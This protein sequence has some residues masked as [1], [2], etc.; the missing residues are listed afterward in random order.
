[1]NI[2]D[3][4]QTETID[5]TASEAY[6]IGAVLCDES[7]L[8]EFSSIL[9]PEMFQ[10]SLFGRTWQALNSMAASNQPISIPTLMATHKELAGRIGIK[11]LMSYTTAYIGRSDAHW[12]VQKI[13]EMHYRRMI[14]KGSIELQKRATDLTGTS[15]DELKGAF[16]QIAYSFEQGA[17][18]GL[19]AGADQAVRWLESVE[20]RQKDPTIA[21]G[22]QTGWTDLDLITLGWQ[23]GD[24]IIIGGRTSVGKTAFATENMIRLRDNGCKVAMFSLEMSSEQVKNRLA[25]NIAD[26]RLASIRTGRMEMEELIR[27]GNTIDTISD[28]AIDDNRG[29]TTDYIV[30]E[31]KRWKRMNGL[32]FVVVDYLQEI[33]EPPQPQDNTGSALGRV[34]RKLRK[35]AKDCDCALMALS[36]LTRDAEG[37]A[38]KISDLFGSSGLES[39][40][41]LIVMLHRDKEESPKM[42]ELNVAKQRNGPTSKVNLTYD[43]AKQRIVG[44][45]DKRYE[46]ARQ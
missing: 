31:M 20:K 22:M 21:F 11:R 10:Q 2:A 39:A 27:V 8:D 25:G 36:Q 34:A 35:A 19:S 44:I 5:S 41:D 23:R 28:I 32:D 33:W 29:V 14:V 16:E 37:K 26:V 42:L 45:H 13:V 17:A 43:L 24:L 6:V 40:A 1:M 38:P 46:G 7:L 12:H 18:S 15:V 9:H 30:A 3:E 4:Q